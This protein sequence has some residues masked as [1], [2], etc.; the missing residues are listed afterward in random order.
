MFQHIPLQVD[1]RRDLGQPHSPLGD[2]HDWLAAFAAYS[3]KKSALLH[4]VE[5]FRRRVTVG[6]ANR[7]VDRF[8]QTRARRTWPGNG[9][10]WPE[11]ADVDIA[12]PVG[13]RHA[14]KRRVQPPITTGSA[15]DVRYSSTC[16]WAATAATP[17][18]T[19]QSV[20]VIS[21]A[22]PRAA[23]PSW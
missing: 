22:G 9:R 12:A 13:L 23:T 1:A 19:R 18:G 10:S 4:L 2:V 11:P 20:S 7:A 21:A 16:S 6:N 8:D 15:V 3:P 5:E 17:S 14:E